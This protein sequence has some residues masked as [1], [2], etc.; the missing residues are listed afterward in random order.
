MAWLLILGLAVSSS[1]DNLGV[2]MSYG[3][4]KIKISHAANMMIAFICF[5][6]SYIG[7]Y[8]G[9][10]ISAILP[11][12]LPVLLAAFI[13]SVIGIRIILLAVPRK[14]QVTAC[15]DVSS[16]K[17]SRF[18]GLLKNPEAADADGSGEIG[19]LE[20]MVLGV[21]VSANAL[22]NGLSAGLIG[23]SPAAISI[24]A[25]VGSFLTI[26]IGCMLGKKAAS[27]RIGSF[28]VGQFSTVLSGAIIL[29]I[30]INTLLF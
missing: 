23:L 7:I 5:L 27:L 26:W 19:M 6:F 1:I 30:A 16:K 13:L 10:W 24:T 12:F 17:E 18:S 9:K 21:A 2:G 3:I 15:V 14:K 20:S 25:A 22:T 11:G 4:R 29:I 8:F 28:H